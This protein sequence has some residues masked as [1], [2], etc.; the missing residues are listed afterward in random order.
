MSEEERLY[1]DRVT[2]ELFHGRFKTDGL[3]YYRQIAKTKKY[4]RR[5]IQRHL[6]KLFPEDSNGAA[7]ALPGPVLYEWTHDQMRLDQEGVVFR[8]IR[9]DLIKYVE[10][11]W[12]ASDARKT[13]FEVLDFLNRNCS[14]DGMIYTD[15]TSEGQRRFLDTILARY[16]NWCRK[17]GVRHDNVG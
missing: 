8:Q 15:L 5:D 2:S 16:R 7:P 6:N 12:P 11:Y 4:T 1:A 10:D 9:D 17:Q 14:T 13:S 3:K